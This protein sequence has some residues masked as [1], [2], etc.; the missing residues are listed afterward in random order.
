MGNYGDGNENLKLPSVFVWEI[1]IFPE[2]RKSKSSVL[3]GFVLPNY[4]FN[5]KLES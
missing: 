5:E 2:I 4:I 1:N 3:F